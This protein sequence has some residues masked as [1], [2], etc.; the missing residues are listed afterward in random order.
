MNSRDQDDDSDTDWDSIY[1]EDTTHGGASGQSRSTTQG[2]APSSAKAREAV[3]ESRREENISRPGESTSQARQTSQ[4]PARSWVSED[5][6]LLDAG[7]PPPSYNDV[8]ASPY[9]SATRDRQSMG[10]RRDEGDGG[11][12]GQVNDEDPLKQRGS[13]Q[14][15]TRRRRLVKLIVL[16]LC[17]SAV[18]VLLG[19][20]WHDKTYDKVSRKRLMFKL[21]FPDRSRIIEE[22][23]CR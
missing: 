16:L 1:D 2:D 23:S 17:V 13:H 5:T 20:T 7:P 18:A 15:H 22:G 3:D 8:A 9:R 10:D 12:M 11:E 4:P 19:T 6:P 21:D 14:R